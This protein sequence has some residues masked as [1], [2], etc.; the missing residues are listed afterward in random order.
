MVN[1]IGQYMQVLDGLKCTYCC[2][3]VDFSGM[4][5]V[6][7]FKKTIGTVS[8]QKIKVDTA[9]IRFVVDAPKME[10]F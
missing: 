2:I 4:V 7:I 1:F 9:G 6:G 5:G 3:G 10:V 8:K